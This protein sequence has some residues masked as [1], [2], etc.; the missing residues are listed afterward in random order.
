MDNRTSPERRQRSKRVYNP[1]ISTK[2]SDVPKITS[3]IVTHQNRLKCLLNSFMRVESSI[4]YKFGNCCVFEMRF[5]RVNEGGVNEGGV[6]NKIRYGIELIF[7]GFVKSSKKYYTRDPTPSKKNLFPF[8]RLEGLTTNFLNI[9]TS[10]LLPNVEYVFFLIRHGNSTHNQ[11]NIFTKFQSLY[12]MD[13]LLTDE[14]DKQAR[15]V[16]D[17]M[18]KYLQNQKLS[19][20]YLFT[21]DLKRTRQT[22]TLIIHQIKPNGITEMIVLPCAHELKYFDDDNCDKRMINYSEASLAG[23]NMMRCDIGSDT[24]DSICDREDKDG[25]N[26]YCC[27]IIYGDTK[28]SVNWLY[29][30]DFY[31][32]GKRDDIYFD[33]IRKSCFD[34]NMIKN[35]IDI[36]SIENIL[37]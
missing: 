16:G 28:L 32:G 3:I 7:D 18:R 30:K 36:I 4:Q 24:T 35:A 2:I 11:Y 31:E 12:K 37:I 10:S 17:F 27:N 23:E 21:S 15:E 19:I 9:R 33:E 20:H 26:L 14:G 6:K 25:R 8:K 1:P 5:I 22:A 34:T 29:Y 13:T